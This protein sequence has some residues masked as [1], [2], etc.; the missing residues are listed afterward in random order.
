[1]QCLHR[2]N[3]VLKPGLH[4]GAWSAQEDAIVR[5]MVSSNIGEVKWS[6]IAQ[7]PWTYRQA[8]QGEM[9]QSLGSSDS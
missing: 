7:A 5:E 8:M 3:K 9:V 2:W 1:M 4:K 6:A